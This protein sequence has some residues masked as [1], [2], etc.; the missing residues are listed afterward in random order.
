MCGPSLW[1]PNSYNRNSG[2]PQTSCSETLSTVPP[3]PY[4]QHSLQHTDLSSAYR[5]VFIKFRIQYYL[6]HSVLSIKRYRQHKPVF[7]IQQFSVYNSIFS[8]SS[9]QYTAKSL[10]YSIIFSVEHYLQHT[11]YILSFVFYIY[12]ALSSAQGIKAYSIFQRCHSLLQG[13]FPSIFCIQKTL[14]R[15]PCKCPTQP[16]A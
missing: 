7:R 5:F 4:Q 16:V 2:S 10:I 11:V 14:L 12:R 15:G 8:N 13:Y 1:P 3:R 6:Q 9:L